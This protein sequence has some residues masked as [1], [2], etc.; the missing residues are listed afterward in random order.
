MTHRPACETGQ[1]TPA[2]PARKRLLDTSRSGSTVTPVTRA[3]ATANAAS[4]AGAGSVP[5]RIAAARSAA[6]SARGVQDAGPVPGARTSRD[7]VTAGSGMAR[8][9]VSQC[10][11]AAAFWRT[12]TGNACR[13]GL[14][15]RGVTLDRGG[16]PSVG[17]GHHQHR[18]V[19]VEHQVRHDEDGEAAAAAGPHDGHPDRPLADV[20]E[21][22]RQVSGLA[23][24]RDRPRIQASPASTI[25]ELDLAVAVHDLPGGPS[26]SGRT[27]CACS[28]SDS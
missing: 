12:P 17:L 28:R 9:W 25:S 6:G 19:A 11:S 8:R 23:P 3:N 18:A 13:R 1:T 27:G 22:C 24:R 15:Q 21:G 14:F 7:G 2:N 4:R 26:P 5:A 16:G 20:V 10:R